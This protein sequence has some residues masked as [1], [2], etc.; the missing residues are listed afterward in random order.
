MSM[1]KDIADLIADGGYGTVTTN[2]FCADLPDTP[3]TLAA[4]FEYAGS[5]P[6]LGETLDQ[7]GCQI[8]VRSMVYETARTLLQNIQNLL[9]RIGDTNDATYFDG[10]TLNGKDYIRIVPAQGINDIG[11]DSKGRTELTQNFYVIKR[12]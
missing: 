9:I 12:R 1:V 10:V 3:D 8:R 6:L 11:K 4:V 7:P 5:Q 2:I